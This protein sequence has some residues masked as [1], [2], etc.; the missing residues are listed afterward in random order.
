MRMP[1]L[2]QP[3][4]SG[5]HGEAYKRA[6]DDKMIM[7]LVMAYDCIWNLLYEPADVPTPDVH[8]NARANL[9]NLGSIL[10]HVLGEEVFDTCPS[11]LSFPDE[12]LG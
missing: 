8:A 1:R 6:L 3:L 11:Q 2:Q 10:E 4:F 7:R 5:E 12:I 9:N